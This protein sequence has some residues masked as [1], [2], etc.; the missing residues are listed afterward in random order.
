MKTVSIMGALAISL[1]SATAANAATVFE[2]FPN[3][4]TAG[5]TALEA[6][7][8][9]GGAGG[10]YSSFSLATEQ[11]L[12]KAFVL[13]APF[14]DPNNASMRIMIFKDGGDDLP[15]LNG[16]HGSLLP[17]I[18]SQWFTEPTSMTPEPGGWSL[19]EFALPDW[20]VAAGKYWI[21][22]DGYR[23]TVPL[24]S[25]ATP[26]HS[27]SIGTQFS[28]G[29]LITRNAPNEALGFSLNGLDVHSAGV[30]EPSTWALMLLGFGLVGASVRRRPARAVA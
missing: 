9:C 21:Q 4:A 23:A 7:S 8:S 15:A 25:T 18:F 17:A 12:N 22:F 27:R 29:D 6:C 20:T 14:N 1:A 2:S 19:A 5:F 30:P 28:N 3:F 11:T 26:S 24:Y 10:I 16:P 13:I